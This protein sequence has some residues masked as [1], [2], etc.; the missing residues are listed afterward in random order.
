MKAK[1][2]DLLRREKAVLSGETM[3]SELGVSRVAI[4]KHIRKLQE[5]GYTIHTSSGG[6]RLDQDPD[7]MYPWEFPEREKH[8]HFF[9]EVESTMD[10]ARKMARD[11]CPPF[12]VVIAERQKKGR[13]R[14]KRLWLSDAGGLYF[15]VVLRPRIPAVLSLKINFTAS[16]VLVKILR[17]MYDIDAR[18]KWPND[19]LVGRKKICGMLSEME[20]E[21]DAVSFL[22]IGLGIN[23]NNRPVPETGEAVSLMELTGSAVSRRDL[24]SSFLDEFENRLERRGID[25]AVSEW[26]KY[27]GTIG[28][29]VKIVTVN[30]TQEG[31]AVDVDDD[32]ALI[33]K[34]RDGSLH[35]VIYGDCFYTP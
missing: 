3:S 15:T 12:T 10:I 17:R 5:A 32:G 9:E 13:G 16:L 35:R 33:L 7:M 11:G 22:N 8:I 6:Y 23:V 21:T 20:A 4:W 2:L 27:S 31:V 1:I 30:D 28:K 18:V 34:R 29:R 19:I 24:L 14:L 26:K 25:H